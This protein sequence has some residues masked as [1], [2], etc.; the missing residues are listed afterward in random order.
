MRSSGDRGRT[1]T[2]GLPLLCCHAYPGSHE[3]HG[4]HAGYGSL[5]GHTLVHG[6]YG[7]LRGHTLVHAGY[8]S[9]RGPTGP[10]G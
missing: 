8:G 3:G 9:P 4:G 5:R 10:W 7:S 2:S 1:H 6:G